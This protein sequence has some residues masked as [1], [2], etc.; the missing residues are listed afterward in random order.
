M[1]AGGGGGDRSDHLSGGRRRT[2][3]WIQNFNDVINCS[4]RNWLCSDLQFDSGALTSAVGLLILKS[5]HQ[6]QPRLD[7]KM[8]ME[9]YEWEGGVRSEVCRT[10]LGRKGQITG[11]WFLTTWEKTRKYPPPPPATRLASDI[12]SDECHLRISQYTVSVTLQILPCRNRKFSSNHSK[13]RSF[14]WISACFSAWDWPRISG[15]IW[16]P[17]SPGVCLEL[18][19]IITI[20]L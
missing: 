12:W 8:S 10:W 18:A 7:I 4:E 17:V 6:Y 19:G 9:K 3:L 11:Q 5:E 20:K 15:F 1:T 13:T 2:K 16:S 14:H